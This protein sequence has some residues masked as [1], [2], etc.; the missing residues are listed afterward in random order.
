MS[1]ALTI[2]R[3]GT[4]YSLTQLAED[5]E[6]ANAAAAA[7][8]AAAGGAP[9]GAAPMCP[10]SELRGALL[11]LYSFPGVDA[12][13][14]K[15]VRSFGDLRAAAAAAA[16]VP[17]V[18]ARWAGASDDDG[19]RLDAGSSDD[20][21]SASAQVVPQ[22]SVLDALL[23][24]E[25]EDRAEA[26]LF[27][28]DV[29]ACP[30]RTLPGA[31]GFVAQLNEGRATQKRPTEFRVD[32]VDQPFD[33]SKFHFGKA[34]QREVLFQFQPSASATPAFAP[35]APAA[36]SPNLVFINVS[37]IEYGH[38]LLVPRALEALN[39]VATPATLA[40]ALAFAREAANPYLRVGFNSM[41]AYATINHLHF[42]AYYLGAPMAIERAPTAPLTLPG[43]RG[44]G[45]FAARKRGGVRVA[46]LEGY[47]VRALVFEVGDS[48]AA[49]AAAVGGACERLTAASVPHNL[50][51]VDRGAR[52]FLVPNAF[53]ERKARGELPE[54]VAETQVDPAV[55]EISG[56]MVLK[57]AEDYARADQAWAWRLLELASVSEARFGEVVAL[58]L[59]EA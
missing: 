28:Y 57:R 26:G 8:A 1:P 43:G 13:A 9:P 18:D 16:G 37:P 15:R 14:A 41:G 49:L 36:P 6:P 55:F 47:P 7:A 11:P 2:R 51:I 38:V 25:W 32:Q 50:M 19:G 4:V 42:Q 29:T 35:A 27:R 3:Q 39:Q 21:S 56:H 52:V 59:G 46:R 58:A 23:L 12:Y 34:L 44:G 31:Y 22:R 48:L 53:A 24:A 45:A 5:S 54:D 33:G 17:D 40:L 20:S 10:V 30:T